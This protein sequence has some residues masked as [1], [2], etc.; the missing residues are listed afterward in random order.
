MIFAMDP[1][2]KTLRFGRKRKHE[3]DEDEDGDES[4]ARSS[5]GLGLGFVPTSAMQPTLNDDVRDEPPPPA[6]GSGPS[7][8]GKKGKL[9]F[10]QRQMMKMGWKEGEGLGKDKQGRNTAIEANLRPTKVGLGAVK[11][12]SEQEKKEEKR[13]AALMG[14]TIIDSDE[15]RRKAKKE[16]KKKRLVAGGSSALDS[17]ASTPRQ[18]KAKFLTRTEMEK[19]G[20][21][22]P[23]VFSQVL[24][25][26]GRDRQTITAGSGLMT[27]TNREPPDSDEVERMK[28]NE[29]VYAELNSYKE[30]FDSLAVRKKFLAL[31]VDDD[32][33]LLTKGKEKLRTYTE[34]E[35][36]ATELYDITI[37]QDMTPMTKWNHVT[38]KLMGST[39]HNPDELAELSVALLAPIM[40]A[41]SQD[42]LVLQEPTQFADELVGLDGIL[43]AAYP[44]SSDMQRYNEDQVHRNDIHQTR[45]STT[46]YETM[47]YKLWFPKVLS[48]LKDWDAREP[49][50]IL[51]LFQAWNKILPPFVKSQFL[52]NIARKLDETV[53]KW[54]PRKHHKYPRD[55]PHNWLFCWLPHLPTYQ[56]DPMSK[57][58]LVADVKRKWRSVIDH[59]D[60]KDGVIPGLLEWKPKLS[61]RKKGNRS[62]KDDVW[63]QLVLNHILV[64]MGR[65]LSRYF[66]MEPSSQRRNLNALAD[67]LL[68]DGIISTRAL[69]EL[70]VVEVFP[71]FHS[72]LY[73]WLVSPNPNYGEIADWIK[74]WHAE[75]LPPEI[76]SLPS[77]MVEFEKSL[78]LVNQALVLGEKAAKYHLPRPSTRSEDDAKERKIRKEQEK[79]SAAAAL[80]ARDPLPFEKAAKKQQENTFKD[81][82]EDFCI[83]NDYQFIPLRNRTSAEG[84]PMFRITP[85]NDGKGGLTGWFILSPDSSVFMA[86]VPGYAGIQVINEAGAG[87]ALHAFLDGE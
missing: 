28:V 72:V 77:V 34:F 68:W 38:L 54:K 85:R 57:T 83:E 17:G 87:T 62:R 53:Q 52:E 11:E 59:W 20:M 61:S 55:L 43:G 84:H 25:M 48:A 5:F 32:A 74:W 73:E 18:Q 14:E 23:D 75:V 81:V 37:S 70:L 42:W 56:T 8:F 33:E 76:L 71:K 15:E 69:G 26:T 58:G 44:G 35:S 12:K 24:D 46:P 3:N 19:S 4:M 47:I 82:L 40:Q 67:V 80:A 65:Y 79:A 60:L 6:S 30:E 31:R 10:A 9:S 29:R 36:L 13:H 50:P 7:A 22:V 51:E 1:A 21:Q 86:Q 2:D 16:R 27:P 45:K 49:G 39:A 64:R 41:Y 78:T 66:D 63:Q